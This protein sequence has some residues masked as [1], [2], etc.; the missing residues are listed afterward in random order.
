MVN[1][2]IPERRRSAFVATPEATGTPSL[3]IYGFRPFFILAACWSILVVGVST[4]T[5]SG[6]WVAPWPQDPYAWHAHEL[7]FG[8]GSA[9]VAG[10]L[11]TATPNWTDRA[12]IPAAVVLGLVALWLA[13]RAANLAPP[14]FPGYWVVTI[15]GAF[16]PLLT[17]IVARDIFAARYWRNLKIVALLSVYACANLGHPA[18]GI[19]GQSS[20]ISLRLGLTA[21]IGLCI[22]IGARMA[23]GFTRSWFD[24]RGIDRCV[25]YFGNVDRIALVTAAIACVQWLIQPTGEATGATLIIAAVCNAH[26]LLRWQ[27]WA[28]WRQPMIFVLHIGYGLIVAGFLLLGVAAIEPQLIRPSIALHA[29][30][31]GAVG[32]LTLAVMTRAPLGHAGQLQEASVGACIS[33]GAIVVATAARLSAGFVPAMQAQFT[34]LAGIGWIVGFAVYLISYGPLLLGR[35]RPPIH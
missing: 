18:T 2:N 28:T 17:A 21:L 10:F 14:S 11:L 22:V 29:W 7:L 13:G 35:H 27:G 24:S 32:T 26:R 4:A 6:Y 34:T 33:Y 5:F 20:Q 12:P 31:S 19:L 8:Y 23:C 15:D 3:L 16:L 30:T 25:P 9:A 1:S